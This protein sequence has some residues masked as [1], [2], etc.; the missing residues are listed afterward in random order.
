MACSAIL[1]WWAPKIPPWPR[2]QRERCGVDSSLP[3]RALQSEIFSVNACRGRMSRR[4]PEP[5]GVHGALRLNF[6]LNLTQPIQRAAGIAE[7]YEARRIVDLVLRD[8]LA[9]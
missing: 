6:C 7:K 4:L 1:V 3:Q 5:I 9:K 8:R 2:L